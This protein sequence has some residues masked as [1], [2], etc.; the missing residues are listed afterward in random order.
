MGNTLR[1]VNA[2]L[3]PKSRQIFKYSKNH[4]Q[5]QDVSQMKREAPPPQYLIE[6]LTL[7]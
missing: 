5:S 3:I 1:I 4:V 6:E 7:E 2:Q